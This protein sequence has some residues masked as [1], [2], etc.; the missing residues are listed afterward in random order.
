MEIMHVT[1]NDFQ[2]KVLNSTVPVIVDFWASWCGPC[3][4]LA[5]VL[6]TIAQE[7]EDVAV[8]KV[9]V[10]ENMNLASTY[11]ISSIPN[12]VLFKNGQPAA[13]SVGFVPK[14]ALLANLGL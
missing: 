3:K 4:M 13:Q 8:A 11:G 6:E 10:D 7:R 14:D 1:E 5:P 2:E 9:D 12:V